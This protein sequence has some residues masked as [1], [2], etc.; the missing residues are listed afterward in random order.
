LFWDFIEPYRNVLCSSEFIVK[1]GAS[2]RTQLVAA[3]IDIFVGAKGGPPV[4]AVAV[5]AVKIG[6][7]AVCNE[8]G[9]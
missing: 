2:D 6:L 3:I 4:V 7:G 8:K 5:L 9:R 1:A